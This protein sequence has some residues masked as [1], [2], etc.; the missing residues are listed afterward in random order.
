VTH[1]TELRTPVGKLQ[2]ASRIRPVD[3]CSVTSVVWKLVVENGEHNRIHRKKLINLEAFPKFPRSLSGGRGGI[4][5]MKL[6]DSVMQYFRR[7]TFDRGEG[8]FMHYLLRYRTVSTHDIKSK[9]NVN[10]NKIKIKAIHQDR[11]K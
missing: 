9:N 11:W 5:T 8:Q 2:P 7:L 3:P 10:K 6:Q 1:S 4:C